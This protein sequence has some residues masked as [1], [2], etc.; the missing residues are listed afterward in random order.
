MAKFEKGNKIGN[1]FTSSNQP[2]KRGRKPSVYKQVAAILGEKFKIELSKEDFF[3]IQQWLLEMPMMKLK[4]II[5]DPETPSFIAVHIAA[6]MSDAK[7]G[8]TDSVERIYDRLF[9]RASQPID[10]EGDI[11]VKKD[12][13]LT[14][15]TDDE[16]EM[17]AQMIEKAKVKIKD[18]QQKPDTQDTG[19]TK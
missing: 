13:D 18:D 6:I 5:K 11:N 12:Y 15:Y 19:T 3:K 4:D 8:K 17:M 16:I 14:A 7:N 2:K 1:R 9:G 10:L